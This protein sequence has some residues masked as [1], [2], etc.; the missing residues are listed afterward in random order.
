MLGWMCRDTHLREWCPRTPLFRTPGDAESDATGFGHRSGGAGET[1]GSGVG[2]AE[3]ALEPSD[4]RT[5]SS[6]GLWIGFVDALGRVS[7]RGCGRGV[8]V[9][10]AHRTIGVRAWKL[11]IP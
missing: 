6:L 11:S 7:W 3:L 8:W 4:Q 10:R 1:L 5:V 2:V 9:C